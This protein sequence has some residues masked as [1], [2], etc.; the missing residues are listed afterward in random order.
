M[1]FSLGVKAVESNSLSFS[2]VQLLGINLYC[3][4]IAVLHLSMC[5]LAWS[6][7]YHYSLVLQ[8]IMLRWWIIATRAVCSFTSLAC[9]WD[10]IHSKWNYFPS[11][12]P[13]IY[14]GNNPSLHE[15]AASQLKTLRQ[16]YDHQ[17]Q[18]IVE[19]MIK[20]IFIEFHFG[21]RLRDTFIEREPVFVWARVFMFIF[22][23]VH[24]LWW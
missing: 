20:Y 22:V 7:H 5:V 8:Y 9:K 14:L 10:F 17:K 6:G 4:P 24:P 21:R 18:F 1:Y 12:F 3:I 13:L 23:C 11:E 2:N 16:R 19:Y 15:I